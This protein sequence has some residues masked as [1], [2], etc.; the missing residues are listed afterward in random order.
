ML[1]ILLGKDKKLNPRS[2]R[3]FSVKEGKGRKNGIIYGTDGSS[4]IGL[5]D[6]WG[7]GY[8]VRL[9]LDYDGKI[10]VNPKT[11]ETLKDRH[12]AIWSAGPDRV[13]DTEDDVKTW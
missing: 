5:F 4:V 9:D 1:E 8:K 10:V 2:I 7:H 6:P 3:F 12:A 11:G 13:F